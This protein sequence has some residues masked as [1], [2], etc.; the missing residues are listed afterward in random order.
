MPDMVE[1]NDLVPVLEGRRDEPPHVLIAAI[2]MGEDHGLLAAA[3]TL[4]LFLCAPDKLSSGA[5]GFGVDESG[6]HSRGSRIW[7]DVPGGIRLW[8]RPQPLYIVPPSSELRYDL[9]QV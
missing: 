6:S 3:E 2:A 8:V 7:M 5:L 1:E 4:T 9:L